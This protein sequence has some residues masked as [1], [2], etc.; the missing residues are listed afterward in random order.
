MGKGKISRVLITALVTVMVFGLVASPVAA[1]PAEMVKVLIGFDRQPGP[2]EE[3]TVRG[4]GGSIK[5]TYHLVPAIAASVPQAAIDRLLRNPRVTRVEPDIEVR[6]IDQ[7]L[8]WGVN[9][10]D[11]D[12][13][14]STGN[15]GAG[16]KVAVLDTGIDLEHPDLSV[17]DGVNFAGGGKDADDKN[18]HGSHVAGT[19]AALDN[20]IGVIGVAPNVSLYAVKVLG[21]GGTG[22]YSDVI[23][24]LE[25]A[26]DNGMQVTNNSYG[27]TGDPGQTV[28]D[29]FDAAYAAGIINIAA[30]GNEYRDDVI[31]PARWG[32]VVA[33]SAT[34]TDDTLASFSS[35]GPEVELAAPGK[36]IY[37]TYKDGGYATLSGTS[38]ASPHV[39]G[40]AALVI[41]AGIVNDGDNSHG[42]ANEVRDRLNVTAEDIGLLAEEQGNGLVDAEAAAISTTGKPPTVSWVNPKEG[43]TISGGATIQIDASDTED[44]AGTLTVEWRIDGGTWQKATYNSTSGYYEDGWDTTTVSDGNHNLDARATDS[45][46]NI[47]TASITVTTENT[48]N[49]PTASW[50]NPK[51]GDTVKDTVTI[52]VDADDDRDAAGTLTVEWRVDGGAWQAAT[53]NSS[54][55]YYEASWDTTGVVDG[56]HTLDARATDS[57]AN[58]SSPATI[59]VT[60]NNAGGSSADM[61]V[62]EMTWAE[63]H[64][65]RGGSFTD[66]MV[67]VDVNQDSDGDAVAESGDDPASNAA[68]TL[69]LTHDTDGDGVFEP[70]TGDDY[71]TFQADT[72]SGGQIT[73]TLKFAPAGDYRAEVTK[74]THDTLTWDS[75][76]D[77][78]N[79]DF[80]TLQ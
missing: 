40:T 62:W 70:G 9:R 15:K 27:S 56:D 73:F 79:P 32:S 3:A 48:D 6:A 51:D 50:V 26:V 55:G 43:D 2:D 66:L 1:Q 63:K 39:A 14:H 5:Y 71:W 33:V 7:V 11:A 52:H 64:F 47:V 23:A 10:I 24:G 49:A 18:G 74:L 77:A 35:V 29:A 69:V 54:S 22:S 42:I 8:P 59:M 46:G 72:N 38:M 37:S 4:V 25:W 44:A 20:T 30:A 60:V 13:V 75:S 16:V 58:V 67:T 17:A 76:L 12:V 31:Y 45:D 34:T 19:I 68:V 21:N 78:D 65:G 28:K 41:A 36:D 57:G 53:Y 61:Y 80:Y